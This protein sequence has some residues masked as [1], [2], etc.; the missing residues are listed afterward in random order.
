MKPDDLDRELQAHLACEAD[1]HRER[2]LTA[3]DAQLAARRALGR[4]TAIKEQVR[5][6]S[7]LAAIDDCAQDLRYGVR[8]LRRHSGFAIVA[9]LTLALG[10]GATTLVFSV[11]DA[12]LLR[13]LPYADADRLV[14][15]WE[16]V[17]IPGYTNP[18]NTPAPGNFRDW[19]D[20]NSTFI[21]IAAI[22][23]GV[24]NL[25]DAGEPIRTEGAMVSAS[26]FRLLQVRPILG[27][28]FTP[29]E[30][31]AAPSRV[32]VLGYGLWTDRFGADPSIVGRTIRLS[33]EPY[34]VL[35][36]MPRG[37]QFP[38][39]EDQIWAPLGLTPQQLANHDGHFL[40]VLGRLKPHVTLAQAQ[41]DVE[42]IAAR[43]TEQY[44]NSNTGV[45]VSM[46]LLTEQVVG[47]VRRPLLIVLGVVGF[48]LLMVCTNIGALLLARASSRGRE[49]A[50]RT[51]LGASRIRL[52]RQLLAEGVVLAA[53]GG[54]LGLALALIGISVLRWLAPAVVPRINDIEI[55]RS[56]AL[57]NGSVA[58]L[59]GAICGVIPA[60]RSKRD[61]SD[62]LRDDSR[63]TA[64]RTSLRTR[65][66]LVVVQ[67][68]LGVVVL[69]GAGLLLRSFVGL[70]HV[71]VG[72]RSDG[73]LTFRVALPAV[74][75]R[76]EQQ[77]SGFYQQ[78]ADRLKALP[79][80]SSAAAISFLPLTMSGRITGVSID[81]DAARAPG[82]VRM[83]DFR[84]VSPGYFAAMSIAMRAG[85]D[86]AWS[87]TPATQPVIVVS[88]TMARKF[89]PDQS[90]VGQRVKRGRPDSDEP[91]VTVVG[92][93]SDVRQFDLVSVPR[94][95][96]YF[97]A[98]QDHGT[99]DTLRDWVVR[100]SS[101]PKA[102]LPSVRS[103]VWSIDATLPVT[104]VETMTE[105]RGAAT[106]SQ[107]FT[108]L[109]V[110]VFAVLA[111]ILAA[112]GLYGVTAYNVSQRT[113]ELGI[114]VAL[115]ARRGSLLRGVLAQGARLTIVGLLIGTVAALA[116]TELMST[117]L[118]EIGPRDPVTFAG[119]TMLLLLVAVAASWGP[120]HRA[121]RVN[122]VVALKT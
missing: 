64:G 50:V 7:P 93:V 15:V 72:F 76:T 111:L 58:L 115:G 89:W 51:A 10:V 113:R 86:V 61:L 90:A 66:G 46:L 116:L 101:D 39:A 91:W 44:P 88:E 105:V 71:P 35:G 117:L 25:T 69:V 96:M 108:L 54:A 11:V 45:G 27:R 87:D 102:V 57:F 59:A 19:R 48:L 42:T 36:I 53:M 30:D 60:L 78:L 40:R 118:F 109:V 32:V 79:G 26:L 81:G 2:G 16:D 65:N 68:A 99:G 17:K 56:I 70:L 24:W 80:V 55:N 112:I 100:T 119:V 107:R 23:D 122:P 41:A 73:I 120:A 22:R 77:R 34:T 49:F 8:I 12:V 1:E 28:L 92:V 82:Q 47:D 94:P 37:F 106:A 104:R 18:R 98:S 38:D 75:Y 13:P 83:V 84:S 110:G 14:M 31:G 114:R 5:A 103:A 62:T 6:L 20:Q 29:E 85:R 3:E 121:T 74:R 4:E 67:V 21:D 97:P 52:L 43:L 95:A 9:A 33:D 63:A